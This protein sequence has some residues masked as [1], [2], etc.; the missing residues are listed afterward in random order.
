LKFWVRCAV[1]AALIG[2]VIQK[3]NWR[4]LAALIAACDSHWIVAGSILTP[5]LI[6]G[7][8]LRWRIFLAEQRI[9]APFRRL[10]PLTWAGQFFNAVL[11]GSTGGDVVKIYQLCRLYPEHKAAAAASVVADRLSALI[12]LLAMCAGAFVLDPI[13]LRAVL[14]ARVATATLLLWSLGA[15]ALGTGAAWLFF[16][17]LRLT[18][19]GSRVE[20]TLRALRQNLRFNSGSLSALALAFALHCLNFFITYSFCRALHLTITYPQILLLMPVLLFVVLLPI[21]INGHGLRE[22]LLIAYFKHFGVTIVGEGHTGVQELAVA[23]SLIGVTNELL[24]S[25][26]GGLCYLLSRRRRPDSV[27][28]V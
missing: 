8:A 17:A 7:L 11:P 26:P 16:R 9:G 15:A 12:A 2:V 14:S 5:I 28:S 13:P 27:H 24:W 19:I 6:A 1:S 10:F 23:A 4:R 25:A 20:R 21:T 22:L 18:R 3:V